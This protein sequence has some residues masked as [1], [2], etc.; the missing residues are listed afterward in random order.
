MDEAATA[1]DNSKPMNEDPVVVAAAADVEEQKKSDPADGGAPPKEEGEGAPPPQEKKEDEST[2]SNAEKD[3]EPTSEDDP[4]APVVATA[5]VGGRA[6]RERKTVK[7]FNPEDFVEEKKELVIPNG[8]GTKLEDMPN[9]VENF[10]VVTWSSPQ[11]KMLYSI[12]FGV[13]KKKEF[14]K[15]LLEFNGLVYVEGTEEDE[16]EKL[17][18]KMYKLKMPELRSVMDLA[19]IDRSG[20]SFEGKTAGKEE[21]CQRILDWLEKPKASG[22]KKGSLA[23][24]SGGKKRKSSGSSS[25]AAEKKKKKEKAAPEKKDKKKPAKKQKTAANKVSAEKADSSGSESED[26]PI[27]GVSKDQLRAKVKSIVEKSDPDTLTVK[28]VRKMLE[29]V[30]DTDLSTAVQ[31][32]TIRALVMEV[33]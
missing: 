4:P 30:Y 5:T 16:R 6:K 20:D 31:K 25:A 8:T 24:S 12:V 32:D 11:L 7:S 23:K 29:D 18:E 22:K 17:R 26:E 28:K 10:T 1:P 9:V 3:A 14:K 19:D 13:G 2:S 21:L 27:T 33:M 15:H